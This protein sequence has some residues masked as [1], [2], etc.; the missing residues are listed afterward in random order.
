MNQIFIIA[1][2]HFGH[3]NII[4]YESRP[5]DSIEDMDSVMIDSW[6]MTVD[7]DDIIY[8][9]GDFALTGSDKTK[10]VI[11][12]LNGKKHIIIGSHDR[13]ATWYKNNGF[14]TATKKIMVIPIDM[15]DNANGTIERINVLLTHEPIDDESVLNALDRVLNIHGHIH[16][17]HGWYEHTGRHVCVSVERTS[18]KP[19]L[20]ASV[21]KNWLA[22]PRLSITKNE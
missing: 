9:L 22:A 13:T 16:S 2:T 11:E 18:Y 10:E 8:V 5:F 19:V 21:I 20:L 12:S 6:N 17:K 1:D 7:D 4:E 3:R 15:R 14:E